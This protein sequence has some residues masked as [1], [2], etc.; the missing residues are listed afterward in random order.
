MRY[1]YLLYFLILPLQANASLENQINQLLK[2]NYRT[3]FAIKAINLAT[4]KEIYSYHPYQ[5]ML[6]A[7]VLKSFT[8][9]AALEYLGPQFTYNTLI[10]ADKNNITS[11]GMLRG[12][13]YLKFAG[14]PSLTIDDLSRLIKQANLKEITGKI[15]IDDFIF[16]Q[17]YFADGVSWDDH[18]FCFSAPSSAI[19]IGN[20]CFNPIFEPSKNIG[21]LAILTGDSFANINNEII[22]QN[23][24]SCSPELKAN[25]DNSYSLNGCIDIE[26]KAIPLKIAYQ[27]PR[28]M[29]KALVAKLLK[30]HHIVWNKQIIFAKSPEAMAIIAQHNSKPLHELV[31][32]MQKESDNLAANNISK[33]IGA[34][35]YK[36]Q[37]NF[38]NGVKAI[39]EI[40]AT[41]ANIDFSETR[42]VD[43]SGQSRYNLIAADNLSSLFISAYNNKKLWPYFSQSLAILGVDGTLKERFAE[44]PHL[45][46]KIYAKTGGMQGANSLVGYIHK[47][48]GQILVF[49]IISNGYV[50][51]KDKLNKVIAQILDILH[52]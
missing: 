48:D 27:D 51:P 14:D 45:H 43:G 9:Y 23:D 21:E 24:K 13:L 36:K 28:L 40:I 5:R 22:T 12:D 1:L 33:T 19:A 7:S 30:E 17:N 44:H 41:K 25:P 49:S 18:K 3:S 52:K 31:S 47:D 16:D 15:I 11:D 4:G 35:Y 38:K 50:G 29:I 42:M 2:E 46:S 6:P 26:S 10:L 34:A 37:G 20:N 39:Q 32:N 8:A